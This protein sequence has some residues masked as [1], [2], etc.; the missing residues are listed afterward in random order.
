M[1]PN[2]FEV[3]IENPDRDFQLSLQDEHHQQVWSCVIRK[4]QFEIIP[5]EVIFTYNNITLH[6]TLVTQMSTVT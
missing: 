1:T 6:T 5:R 3:F 4:G 2:F